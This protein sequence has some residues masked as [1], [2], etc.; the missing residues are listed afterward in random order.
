MSRRNLDYLDFFRSQGIDI[1]HDWS[2]VEL[3]RPI[4]GL[5]QS[6]EPLETQATMGC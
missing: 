5:D 6:D 4:I 1:N 3:L 2:R